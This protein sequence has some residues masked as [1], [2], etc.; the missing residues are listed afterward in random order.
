MFQSSFQI[1]GTL[2]ISDSFRF[3]RITL[4]DLLHWSSAFKAS[5]LNSCPVKTE[6]FLEEIEYGSKNP[7]GL[8][9]AP[10]TAFQ[11]CFW[12]F[13][14]I[15]LSFQDE[16]MRYRNSR[17]RVECYFLPKACPQSMP[18]L[19]L[20]RSNCTGRVLI[21]VLALIFGLCPRRLAQKFPCEMS[22]SSSTA[23]ARSRTKQISRFVRFARSTFISA[24][25]SFLSYVNFSWHMWGIQDICEV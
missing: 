3:L 6:P 12:A 2:L 20:S 10:S 5:A 8:F 24:Q 19:R 16:G 1:A 14:R 4:L 21:R 15:R 11:V 7:S 25:C 13:F 9:Q 22:M 17:M 23:H 18:A